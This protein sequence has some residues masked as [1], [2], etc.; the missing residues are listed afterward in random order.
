MHKSEVVESGLEQQVE[1]YVEGGIE[2]LIKE[3]R[4][5]VAG[6]FRARG[7]LVKMAGQIYV[8]AVRVLHPNSEDLLEKAAITPSN[9]YL[10][11]FMRPLD[12]DL[13]Q[14]IADDFGLK[15]L[16]HVA[17]ANA[18]GD[19]TLPLRAVDGQHFG[20]LVWQI[21]RPSRFVLMVVLPGLLAVILFV[22]LLSWYVLNSLRRA[23]VAL[24]KRETQFKQAHEITRLGYWHSDQAADIVTISAELAAIL[25]MP[26]PQEC[27]MPYDEYLDRFVHADDSE[28]VRKETDIELVKGARFETEYRLARAEGDERWFREIGE[29]IMDESRVLIGKAGTVQD[30]T[31]IKQTEAALRESEERLHQAQK[32]EAMGKLT[33]GVAHDF[34]NLLAI[35][36]GNAELQARKEGDDASLA[37]AI[38]RAAAPPRS[39]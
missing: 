37:E 8:A 1:G 13:F 24:T 31:A 5:A 18:Y 38:L 29:P 16:T 11:I 9:A 7:G 30:V 6:E 20:T 25:D 28:R 32:M 22:G 10:V 19:I 36:I 12:E 15:E 3:A 21:N 34:N 26:R 17:D 35:I 23:Q 14:Q 33:G 2:V 27:R 4:H 39:A